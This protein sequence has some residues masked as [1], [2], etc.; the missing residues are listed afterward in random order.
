M[1][2]VEGNRSRVGWRQ[3]RQCL[4]ERLKTVRERG[5]KVEALLKERRIWIENTDEWGD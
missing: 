4:G 3:T 5:G 1:E 2:T